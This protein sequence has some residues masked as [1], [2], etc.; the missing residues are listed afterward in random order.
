VLAARQARGTCSR[1]AACAGCTWRGR[2]AGVGAAV[3]GRGG[4]DTSRPNTAEAMRRALVGA[5]AGA[6]LASR[7]LSAAA[8]AG[9]DAKGETVGRRA[10]QR[11]Y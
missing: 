2:A 3:A 6:M 1:R 7:G 10:G 5:A 4:A 9:D 8:A 11:G